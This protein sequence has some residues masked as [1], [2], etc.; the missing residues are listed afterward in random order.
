MK[1]ALGYWLM[2]NAGL[3][4]MRLGRKPKAKSQKRKGRTI[5]PPCEIKNYSFVLRNLSALAITDTE[6]KL[7]AA[8]AYTGCSS[9]P[10]NGYKMPAAMGT[11]RRL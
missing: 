5:P 4:M 8:A 9:N 6:L 3:T 11:P 1:T 10:M 2:A 7:M